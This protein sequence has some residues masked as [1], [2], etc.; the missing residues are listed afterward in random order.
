M[1]PEYLDHLADLADPDCL[2]RLSHFDQ[3]ALPLDKRH[4]LDTGVALRRYASHIQR[5]EELLGTNQSLLLTPL[6]TNGVAS[7]NVKTPGDHLKL[8]SRGI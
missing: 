4:Q 8:L 5:L 3:M 2:W 6:S 1:T 7:K